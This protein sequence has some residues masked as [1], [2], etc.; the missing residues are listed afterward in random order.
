MQV[1]FAVKKVKQCKDGYAC[2]YGC[3]SK[4]KSCKSPISGQAANYAD[5]LS[6]QAGKPNP[7]Q[8]PPPP[9]STVAPT[10]KASPQPPPPPPSTVAPTKKAS[11]QPPPPP[12][13]SVAPT[14]KA[15]PQ[16]PP[17]PPS[18][19]SPA[20]GFPTDAQFAASKKSKLKF[21][22]F[23]GGEI[24]K[25]KINGAEYFVK[26]VSPTSAAAEVL[27]QKIAKTIGVESDLV[28]TKKVVIDGKDHLASPLL[29]LKDPVDP[30]EFPPGMRQ[31]LLSKE[32]ALRMATYDY[33]IAST[34]RH[35]GNVASDGKT[36]RLIDNE[37][38]L[39]HEPPGS[40]GNAMKNYDNTIRMNPLLHHA[41]GNSGST[42]EKR[43][44]PIDAAMVQKAFDN[45][46]AT[47]DEINA[48]GLNGSA[49][50]RRVQ[51]AKE[52]ID[53]GEGTFGALMDAFKRN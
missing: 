16:P 18:A 46:Y 19:N 29:K 26:G 28:P 8:P 52:L 13:S 11:P 24:F 38:A 51:I 10:K 34:D 41:T 53:K 4:T 25:T 45:L 22:T 42:S 9:P 48:A 36:I 37:F 23:N 6:Q 31:N 35:V 17:P 20:D 3:V 7:K 27:A 30:D 49:Y 40:N 1:D 2:G 44:M 33:L 47:V 43:S 14:K 15:N 5:W 39:G 12:P 32:A 50:R 21:D